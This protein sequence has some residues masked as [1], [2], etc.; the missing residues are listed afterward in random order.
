MLEFREGW[1]WILRKVCT[2]IEYYRLSMTSRIMK[3]IP[4]MYA[5]RKFASF[6]ELSLHN[7]CHAYTD[8]Y[9]W[10]SR[11]PNSF[12]FSFR[13]DSG[14][15]RNVLHSFSYT[16]FTHMYIVAS[17]YGTCS[18]STSIVNIRQNHVLCVSRKD[19]LI[20]EYRT[21]CL[22]LLLIYLFTG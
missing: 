6:L 7:A 12:M 15:Y 8:T 17:R 13:E 22:F 21:N 16:S 5:S 11:A 1:C 20:Q 4:L 10:P 19:I 3:A 2:T 14:T 9:S 18:F